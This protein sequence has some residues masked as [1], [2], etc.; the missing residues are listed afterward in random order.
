MES[1][2]VERAKLLFSIADS[3]KVLEDNLRQMTAIVMK[4]DQKVKRNINRQEDS[5]PGKRPNK[6]YHVKEEK[7]EE[8]LENSPLQKEL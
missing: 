8:E 5:P 6:Y 7:E 4:L 3:K 2:R 1:D